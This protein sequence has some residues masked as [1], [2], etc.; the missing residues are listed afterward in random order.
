[1]KKVT[2]L[3]V[4]TAA[5]VLKSKAQKIYA[6]C[7]VDQEIKA[8]HTLL[9]RDTVNLVLLDCRPLPEK[10]LLNCDFSEFATSLA[11]MIRKAYPETTI[12]LLEDS[13]YYHHPNR[14]YITMQL[15]IYAYHAWFDPSIYISPYPRGV[16]SGITIFAIIL[17]DNRGDK[18]DK[19]EENISQ[20]KSEPNLWGHKTAKSCL[21]KSYMQAINELLLFIEKNLKK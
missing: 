11:L 4:I 7:P 17:L 21:K 9:D 3:L 2:I 13:S 10:N 1:M 14:G 18:T 6:W 16:W 19:F 12:N 5:I 20:T 8:N 15:S